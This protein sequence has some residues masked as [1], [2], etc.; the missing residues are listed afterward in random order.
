MHAW[1]WCRRS[2]TRGVHC[3][4]ANAQMVA[5]ASI[6]DLWF[7]DA[8]FLSPLLF[9]VWECW[10]PSLDESDVALYFSNA[11]DWP[12][13]ARRSHKEK[14]PLSGSPEFHRVESH[15]YI[16]RAC[17]ICRKI[18]VVQWLLCWLVHVRWDMLCAS[19]YLARICVKALLTLN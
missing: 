2:A 16:C 8:E 11:S 15:P 19:I 14:T 5:S 1:H 3:L 4:V 17:V 18:L 9:R 12:L 10:F 13:V 6:V 7:F